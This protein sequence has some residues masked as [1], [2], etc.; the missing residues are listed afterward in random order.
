MELYFIHPTDFQNY[1]SIVTPCKSAH[2]SCSVFLG[3][4]GYRWRTAAQQ[5]F[6]WEKKTSMVTKVWLAQHRPGDLD[7]NFFAWASW[8][9]PHSSFGRVVEFHQGRGLTPPKGRGFESQQQSY[10]KKCCA[11]VP[12][13]WVPSWRKG[14]SG[15]ACGFLTW[16]TENSRVLRTLGISWCFFMK[17]LAGLNFRLLGT[18]G[19]FL[20]Q[21]LYKKIWT[22]VCLLFL[23]LCCLES[24]HAGLC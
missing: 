18:G 1:Y 11:W 4:C 12:S 6:A 21:R 13:P 10:R 24:K 2:S 15:P 7:W 5:D 19:S 23:G 17:E 3:G 20:N 16:G 8:F 14:S 22:E 9:S